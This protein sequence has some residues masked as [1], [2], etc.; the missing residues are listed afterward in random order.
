[1]D[2][3]SDLSLVQRAKQSDA[4]AF[5]ALIERHYP[6]VY[7]LAYKYAGLPADAEDIAQEVFIRAAR[8]LGGFREAALFTTWLYRITLNAAGEFCA[9]RSRHS[10]GHTAF[11]ELHG[12]H[13]HASA[14]EQTTL[15]LQ[16]LKAIDRL[17]A[18]LK[19]AVLLVFCEGFSHKEAAITLGCAETTVSWRIFQARK[20]LKRLLREEGIDG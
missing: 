6:M 17:P 7:A 20:R 3:W 12:L 4:D 9:R 5:Q 10:D 18:K 1:M 2:Y 19:E 14:P 15:A 16:V 13:A 8:G 11:D